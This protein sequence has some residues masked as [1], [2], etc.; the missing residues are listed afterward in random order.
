METSNV[1][2]ARIEELKGC[3]TTK[4][5]KKRISYLE[6][7]LLLSV[8]DVTDSILESHDAVCEAK[9]M[10]SKEAYGHDP[11][12]YYTLGIS[13][14]VGEM[15]N[16]IVK[17]LRNGSDDGKVK[18]AVE[19]EL[20]DII[21]YSHILAHVLDINLTKLVSDKTKIVVNR[22]KSGYYGLPLKK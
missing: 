13:G 7:E 4:Y 6:K 18:K 5:T 16:K 21:I 19:S 22:S 10:D 9:Q 15:S 1:I 12:M 11:A 2:R 17:A 14:E 20:P 8:E 3:A